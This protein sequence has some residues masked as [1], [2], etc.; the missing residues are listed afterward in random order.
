MTVNAVKNQINQII[1]RDIAEANKI[2]AL[3]KLESG[4]SPA[5]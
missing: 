4:L 5:P 3:D 2:L 1:A